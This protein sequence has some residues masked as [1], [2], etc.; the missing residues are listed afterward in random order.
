[1]PTAGPDEALGMARLIH[2]FVHPTR[3]DK[4]KVSTYGLVIGE[5]IKVCMPNCRCT[6]MVKVRCNGVCADGSECRCRGANMLPALKKGC[7]AC[8]PPASAA[9]PPP[10][11]PPAAPAPAAVAPP[12]AAAPPAAPAPAAPP[13]AA[14]SMAGSAAVRAPAWWG[15]DYS[16]RFAECLRAMSED[17][18]YIHDRFY[19]AP[20]RPRTSAPL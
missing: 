16:E 9:P 1:M 20:C 13:A 19:S 6:T 8:T 2:S 3:T 12:P 10:S 7:P 4:V 17:R 14:A 5:H 15:A 11:P 18:N